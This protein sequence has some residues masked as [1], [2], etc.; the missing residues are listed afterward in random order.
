MSP[1]AQEKSISALAAVPSFHTLS[2]L[3]VAFFYPAKPYAA[4]FLRW[5][6]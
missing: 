3:P 5:N 1:G 6:V 2:L 4:F